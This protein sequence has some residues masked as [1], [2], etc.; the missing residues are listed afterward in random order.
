[1]LKSL[2]ITFNLSYNLIG[3]S[4]PSEIGGMMF[5]QAIDL[6]KN[7]NL[8][9][10]LGYFSNTE[11][12]AFIFELMAN[13]SLEHQLHECNVSLENRMGIANCLVYLHCE[14]DGRQLSTLLHIHGH[15]RL[16]C[17]RGGI[18]REVKLKDGCLQPWNSFDG[19]VEWEL[20]SPQALQLQFRYGRNKL[21]FRRD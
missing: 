11:K 6:S 10:V 18:R 20:R 3:G 12:K 7:R 8:V 19:N 13:G 21:S 15:H 16:R 17:T 5:V 2:A 4:V 9:R 14:F 1:M